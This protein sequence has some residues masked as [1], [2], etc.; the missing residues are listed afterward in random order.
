LVVHVIVAVPLLPG[1]AV[2]AEITGGFESTVVKLAGEP[3]VTGEVALLPNPSTE[4]TR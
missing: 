4:V 3:D 2:T 1:M